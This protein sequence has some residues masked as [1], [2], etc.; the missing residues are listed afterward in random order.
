MRVCATE[1][2]SKSMELDGTKNSPGERK[3]AEKGKEG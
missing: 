3:I 1:S 2:E